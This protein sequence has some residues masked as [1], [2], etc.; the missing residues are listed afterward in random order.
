MISPRLAK[1][2][3]K[4][5]LLDKRTQDGGYFFNHTKGVVSAVKILSDKFKLDKEKMISFAWVH[6]IGYFLNDMENHAE[7][8]LKLLEKEK[9]VLGEAGKDSIL[10]HGNNGV[11]STFEGKIMQIADKLSILNEDF[12]KVLVKNE[13]IKRDEIDFVE[14]MCKK[15]LEM[16]N[17]LNELKAQED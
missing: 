3:A 17:K 16:L 4:K 6:D 8:S 13:K 1:G 7:N 2:L 15:A 12:L 14:M 5:Y 10:N 9:I 11:P